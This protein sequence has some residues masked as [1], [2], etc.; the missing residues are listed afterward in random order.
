MFFFFFHSDSLS[1]LTG[2]QNRFN[3]KDVS[4][5]INN[6]IN[7]QKKK[8]SLFY[9]TVSHSN[10]QR[11]EKADGASK[12]IVKTKNRKIKNTYIC[13]DIKN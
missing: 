1:T 13:A 10:I 7:A 3:L 8:I 4:I 11:N 12:K 6:L 5:K 9:E 2:L